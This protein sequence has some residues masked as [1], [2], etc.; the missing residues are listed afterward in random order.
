MLLALYTR[1]SQTS[2]QAPK[3]ATKIH[4]KK[5]RSSSI[6]GS[7]VLINALQNQ[8]TG[9]GRHS[10]TLGLISVRAKQLVF[11]TD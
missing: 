1:R 5:I 3:D 7:T 4:P 2:I 11:E 10:V 6:E 8:L 9:H